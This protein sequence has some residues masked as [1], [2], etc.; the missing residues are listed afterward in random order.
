MRIV[1]R[2]IFPIQNPKFE[3]IQSKVTRENVGTLLEDMK[4]EKGD[5]LLDLSCNIEFKPLWKK[6]VAKNVSYLNTALERWDGEGL[7]SY[8]KN[9]A[10]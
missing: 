10:E 6:C 8:P 1:V 3:Y 9:E 4:L 5:L 7:T 2:D